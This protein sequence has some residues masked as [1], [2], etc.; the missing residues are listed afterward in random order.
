MERKT[1]HPPIWCSQICTN[2]LNEQCVHECAPKRNTCHFKPK[3]MTLS[4]TPP[5]PT[6][7]FNSEMNAIER[8]KCAGFYLGKI[9]DHL[10]GRQLSYRVRTNNGKVAT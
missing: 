7:E 6:Y 1:A 5:F 8:Q 3:S 2:A 4:E 10:Q 9:V